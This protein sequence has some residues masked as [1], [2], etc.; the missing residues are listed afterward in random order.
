MYTEIV[1]DIT[2]DNAGNNYITGF[3]PKTITF[4]PYSLTSSG[5]VDIF[6]AKIDSRGNWLWA[7]KAGGSNYDRGYSITV[8]KVGNCYMTG[9]FEGTAIFGSKSL[10]SVGN[11]DIFIA[12]IDRD[13]KWLWATKSGGDDYISVEGVSVD[14]IGNI[15]VTGYF[16]DTAVFDSCLIN[17]NGKYDI[18]VAKMDAGGK[19]LWAS[20]AGGTSHDNCNEI[21]SDEAGNIYLIGNFCGSAF[22]GPFVLTTGD[23]PDIFVAKM[24]TNGNWQWAIQAGGS[25]YDIGS[26]IILDDFG[27]CYVTGY[28]RGHA[29][30]GSLM[31]EG[32]ERDD[33]IFV[34]KVDN[35]GSWIWATKSSGNCND[36]GSSITIDDSRNCY[37]TGWFDEEAIFDTY[38]LMCN[39]SS[40]VFV[41][42]L[43]VEGNWQ[44]A[45]QANLENSVAG[46]DITLDARGHCYVAGVFSGT[47]KFGF[48]TLT[49]IH[50]QDIFV[51]KIKSLML[52]NEPLIKIT[53]NYPN[54]IKSQTVISYYIKQDL[55]VSLEVYNLKGQLVET[56]LQGN[57]QA[58]DHTI[59]WNCQNIP[60][61]V[62]FLNM[63]AGNDESVQKMV[64]LR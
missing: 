6:V 24:D 56:L 17:S 38:S 23:Y 20:N 60:A 42:V 61:G 30:F 39:G 53:N 48:H 36:Q 26:S 19:W 54:P 11:S 37:I 7:T 21:I 44:W 64:L 18:F 25:L 52:S 4:G 57:I 12:K 58:G 32:S 29:S 62:Y 31:L 50:D 43:D 28:I 1:D 35:Y 45:T 49:S 14:N 22:F 27:N 47:A 16:E 41:A 10:T 9:Y 3:F 8:D 2:I 40:D 46:Y 59:E 51:A 15:F 5:S 63:K 55:H 13:G 33:D 34:A